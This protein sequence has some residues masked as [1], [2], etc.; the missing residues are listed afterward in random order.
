[1]VQ[2]PDEVRM[3][4]LCPNTDEAERQSMPG[5]GTKVRLSWAPEHM[6]VRPGVR[7]GRATARDRVRPNQVC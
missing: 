5:A 2:L 3:T 1:M 6:H 7:N 4:V